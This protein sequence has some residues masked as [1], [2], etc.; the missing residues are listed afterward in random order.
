MYFL[1]VQLMV[2][3]DGG[4]T[5][6][7]VA[8]STHA[9]NHAMWIDPNDS[10]HV[11]LGNDGGFYISHDRGTN[12]D[13][14]LNLPISTFYAIA[15]DMREPYWVYGGLQDN[16]TWGA[17]VGTRDRNGIG[18]EEW[19]RTGGGDGFYPAVDPTDHNVVY[20]ESQNGALSRF[21]F[22][23]RESKPIRPQ[24]RPG[25]S[26]RYNWSAPLIISPHD[27]RTLWF[28]ANLLFKSTNR[29]DSWERVSPDLTRALNRDN[30]PIMGLTG[31][32]GFGR[33]D[34]TADYGNLS[35]IDESKVRR[36][37]LYTGSD[38]GVIGV[39][40]DGGANW[41]RSEK[42][43]GVPDLTY[44]S[45]VLASQHNEGTAYATFDGHR[46]NDFKP[47]VLKSTDFG[48][49]WTSISAQSARRV[50]VR[51]PRASPRCQPARRRRGVRRV[52]HGQWRPLLGAAEQA[53]WPPHPCTT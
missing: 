18:N 48:R 1:G 8:G 15:I 50:G 43:A 4:R 19:V 41:T 17:P 47:Y 6:R 14:A 28:A 26:L 3:D 44:V 7:R 34:G 33:H 40:R 10:D 49:S 29:G 39:S 53:A 36:G 51:D 35:T 21:D 2:S 22:A 31:P 20:A 23:T 12:W 37:L 30:L 42:F 13:F 5:F 27:N 11:M 32:G 24:A 25:E 45:R 38:D 46:S 16:G 52:R 9:D